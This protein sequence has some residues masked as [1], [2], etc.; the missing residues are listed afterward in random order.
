MWK[1]SLMATTQECSEQY[2]RQYPTK[3]QLYSHL[4][5]TTKTIQVTR[6]RH[7]GHCWRSGDKL[8]SNI[9]LWTPSHGWAKAGWPARTYI[10]QLCAD[11]GR[12]LEDQLGVIDDRD[13]WREKVR[14]IY[15]GSAT[16]LYIYIYIY[17]YIPNVTYVFQFTA[18]LRPSP[19]KRIFR[20]FLESY[21]YNLI[22]NQEKISKNI[23]TNL[24][25]C[26]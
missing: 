14:E 7:A 16:W 22:W 6:T 26:L 19:R 13:R 12:S 9:L 10:Q 4:P 17:I 5:L 11:T 24:V 8:I 21:M 2:W 15:A 23:K 1:K 3:Q 18:G 25:C 20:Q